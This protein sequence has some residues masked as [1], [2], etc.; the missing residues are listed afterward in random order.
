MRSQKREVAMKGLRLAPLGAILMI[1][2]GFAGAAEPPSAVHFYRQPDSKQPF[3]PAVRVGDVIYLSGAIGVSSDGKL[4]EG[5]AA[6]TAAALDRISESL[7]LA[8]GKM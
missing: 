8:G 6:Q 2:A 5:I 4:P 7:A 1:A 3:S